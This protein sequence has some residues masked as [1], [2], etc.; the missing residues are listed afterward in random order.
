MNVERSNVK[1]SRRRKLIRLMSALFDLRAW[2]HL[3]KIVNYYNYSHVQQI[4][5]MGLGREC[6]ISPTATFANAQRISIGDRVVI[7][8]NTRIWAGP[9]L[10]RIIIGDDT[11]I[12]P[13]VVITA[14]DYDFNAGHPVHEQAMICADVILGC[15][16]WVGANATILA[17]RQIGKGAVIGAGAVVT[18]DVPP[19]AIVGGAPAAIIGKRK[20]RHP[21]NLDE[22]TE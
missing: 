3:I 20:L 11:I 16:V 14:S 10:S 19:F 12:G 18:K 21:F 17:G 2:L 7:G 6:G 15:D 1:I 13:N 22:I 9:E 4:R 8:E 5:A